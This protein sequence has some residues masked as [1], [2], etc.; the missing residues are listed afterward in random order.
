MT[1]R[2][3]TFCAT[4]QPQQQL[5]S[6]IQ[7][8]PALIWPESARLQWWMSSSTC[9]E[10]DSLRNIYLGKLLGRQRNADLQQPKS[11]REITYTSTKNLIFFYK[12]NRVPIQIWCSF[13]SGFSWCNKTIPTHVLLVGLYIYYTVLPIY[14]NDLKNL[15]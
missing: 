15:I 10:L 6:L 1:R 2:Q 14:D 3:N 7:V 9:K 11:A 8:I 13:R 4:A 12:R 5:G